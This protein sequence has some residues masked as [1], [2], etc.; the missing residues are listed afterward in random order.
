MTTN[1]ELK[2]AVDTFDQLTDDFLMHYGTPGM[3]WSQQG[4]G[5][6]WQSQAVYAQG[7][8]NPDAKAR[9][10]KEIGQASASTQAINKRAKLH[11]NLRVANDVLGLATSIVSLNPAYATYYAKSIGDAF[12]A[13]SKTKKNDERI[14]A[15]EV[16]KESGLH[17]KKEPCTEKEDMKAVNPGFRNYDDNTKHNCM[18]CTTAYELR[19]RGFDVAANK[20]DVGYSPDVI[21]KY[22]PGSEHKV[23]HDEPTNVMSKSVIKASYGVNVSL[24]K[25]VVE[26]LS[27]QPD[28]ARGNLMVSWPGYG[29]HS[30]VYEVNNG[31][32]VV[33]DCQINKAYKSKNMVISHLA[34]A[35][36]ASYIRTDNAKVDFEKIKEAVH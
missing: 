18:N 16:D 36:G 13:N 8:P 9:G 34:Y 20:R 5:K 17:L 26:E 6:R 32:V 22:F 19:R 25:K 27:K 7:R 11:K 33:R 23:I 10:Q 30:M 35:V 4:P 31:K 3:H 2:H 1:Q 15:L 14:A 12:F 24:G 29:G 28:G 21:Q